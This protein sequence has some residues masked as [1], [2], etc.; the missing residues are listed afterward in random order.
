MNA[1]VPSV[2]IIKD[3]LRL[4]DQIS[5]AK[6]NDLMENNIRLLIFGNL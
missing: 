3:F 1:T 2:N 4:F 5:T 6:K